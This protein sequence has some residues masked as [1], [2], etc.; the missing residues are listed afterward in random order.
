MYSSRKMS[1]D[2]LLVLGGDEVLGEGVELLA[3]GVGTGLGREASK[4]RNKFLPLPRAALRKVLKADPSDG[5][6]GGFCL[7]NSCCLGGA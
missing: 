4:S 6:T 1:G 5:I 2:G 7:R 3:T